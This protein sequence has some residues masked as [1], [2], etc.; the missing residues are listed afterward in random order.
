MVF[1]ETTDMLTIEEVTN[2]QDKWGTAIVK[3]GNIFQSN[4]DYKSAARGMISKMYAY[5]HGGVLFKPTKAAEVQFR[6]TS[7]QALSYFIGGDIPE[8]RGFAI[9]PWSNVRFENHKIKIDNDLAIVMGNYFFT[10]AKTKNE[11]KV[12]F[13]LG[14]KRAND[15]RPII[16]LHHSSLPYEPEN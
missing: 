13:T 4:G 5:N 11:L 9:Q 3:I 12:E 8:D 15:K 2:L 6:E 14:I 7:E 16:F 1:G 10:D